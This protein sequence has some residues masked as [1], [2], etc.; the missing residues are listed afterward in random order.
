MNIELSLNR[1]VRLTT[2][3]SP[4][5]AQSPF[6]PTHP[7]TAGSRASKRARFYHGRRAICRP[8]KGIHQALERFALFSIL[9]ARRRSENALKFRLS[10]VLYVLS[11]RRP[12]V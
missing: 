8:L 6:T 10:P 5:E 2:G 3:A 12:S 7:K 9:I 1:P 11:A 4:P